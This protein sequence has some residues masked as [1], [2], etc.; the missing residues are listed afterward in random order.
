MTSFLDKIKNRR[1][2]YAI[3]KNVAL[4][5]AEIEKSLKML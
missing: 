2:I 3:G 4:E 1:S 5:Q